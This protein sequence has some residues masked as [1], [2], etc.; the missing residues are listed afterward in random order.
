MSL[1]KVLNGNTLIRM[2]THARLAAILWIL[3][4]HTI[5]KAR[6]LIFM[7][8]HIESG[9]CLYLPIYHVFAYLVLSNEDLVA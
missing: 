9:V 7:H 5:N 4:M 6:T 8:P 2:I 1:D 3:H